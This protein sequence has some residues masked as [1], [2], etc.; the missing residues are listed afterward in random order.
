MGKYKICVYTIAKNEEKFVKR[1]MESACEADCV[2]VLDTGSTDRTVEL[3]RE[4]GAIVE[5]ETIVPWRFD[6]ARNRS[7]SLVPDDVDI[8]ACIDL[9]E[10]FHPGWREKLES[11]WQ[12]DTDRASYRYTWNFNADGSEGHVFFPDKIHARHGY[13]WV[14]PVH[15]VLKP[16]HGHPEHHVRVEG[17]QLDH[18]AD[19]S[20]S[21]GQYLPLLELAVA[22][23]PHDDRSMH[24]LGREYMFHGEYT[25][26]IETLVRHLAMP[27]SVWADERAAS[28]RF[29]AR[30]YRAQNQAN[31]AVS[32]YLR[33]IAEAPHLREAY[34]ELSRLYYEMENWTGVLAMTEAALAIENRPETYINEAFA[35]G[36]LPY[37]LASIAWFHVG[38][39]QMAL[40]RAQQALALALPEDAQRITKN[41]ELI[42]KKQSE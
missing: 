18:R 20:K 19:P 22:E 30:C 6:T 5:I 33:A 2:Y 8:C 29:I 24:Y 4:F 1:F 13:C 41:I 10:Y 42:S 3:L 36:S 9:D 28:M 23:R 16:T 31:K 26:A 12:D 39:W 15:E 21:R 40:Q 17:M 27:E 14:N 11:A 37:D 34:V 25:K 32:W 35:W 38:G 7:L